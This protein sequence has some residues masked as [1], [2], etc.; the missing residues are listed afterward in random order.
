MGFR[1]F[2]EDLAL[3]IFI[4]EYGMRQPLISQ[5]VSSNT[6]VATVSKINNDGTVDV[7]LNGQTYT[8]VAAGS[9]PIGVGSNKMMV[10]GTQLL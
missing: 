2:V 5:S 7:T 1:S 8:G 4:K 10:N 6:G 3:Q 9:S